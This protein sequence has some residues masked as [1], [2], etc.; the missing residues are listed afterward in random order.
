M[1]T[2]ITVEITAGNHEQSHTVAADRNSS[3]K[4][5]WRALI[6][7][8]QSLSVLLE[9]ESTGEPEERHGGEAVGEP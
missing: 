1:R 7:R 8:P 6:D 4:H 9:G 3:Q 2:E 5:I